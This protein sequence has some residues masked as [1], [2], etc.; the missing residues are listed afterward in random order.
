MNDLLTLPYDEAGL[1]E[2]YADAP[3]GV[4][5]N[6]VTSVD[7]AAAFRGHTRPLSSPTDL[8]LLLNL[9]RY[10]DVVLVGAGTVRAENYG[11]VQ[12]T[13]GQQQQRVDAGLAPV[14]P[15]A[16]VTAT[17]RLTPDLRV[18]T[19]SAVRPL[20]ITGAIVAEQ[21][22]ELQEVADVVA[23]G[24]VVVEPELLVAALADRGLHRVLCEGGPTLLSGLIDHD[25]VDD[26]CLTVS[27]YLAGTQPVGTPVPST[28]S[29]PSL[30]TLRHVRESDGLLYL[31]YSRA[32][33][34]E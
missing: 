8:R 2:L 24:E 23:A 15:V 25:L 19:E 17:G 4:R 1:D 12:L 3:L 33:G 5:S 29:R 18:F 21:L 34:T 20:V 13:P 31:R 16:M 30:L 28:L 14:P 10:A 32:R 6:M 7:G 11:P 27:P 9:R 26:M 22:L